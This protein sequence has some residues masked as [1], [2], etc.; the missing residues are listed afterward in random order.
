LL[1]EEGSYVAVSLAWRNNFGWIDVGVYNSRSLL[2][3]W[4]NLR[5]CRNVLT[6]TAMRSFLRGAVLVLAEGL[7]R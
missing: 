7:R 5:D 1:G 2:R 6:G 4:L 3:Y